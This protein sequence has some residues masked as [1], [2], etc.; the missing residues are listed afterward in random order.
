MDS[1][2]GSALSIASAVYI[3]TM[4]DEMPTTNVSV[5]MI[6]YH[7]TICSLLI[8][9]NCI[10]L[11]SVG[12]YSKERYGR[13]HTWFANKIV[14]SRAVALVIMRWIFGILHGI[15][16]FLF[17]TN[18]FVP[19]STDNY[20]N[21]CTSGINCTTCTTY[22]LME[23]TLMSLQAGIDYAIMLQVL[24]D[25]LVCGNQKSLSKT[26]DTMINVSIIL[27][28]TGATVLSLLSPNTQIY[29]S[30]GDSTAHIC[31]F[32]R[33]NN[34]SWRLTIAITAVW[35]IGVGLFILALFLF[36]LCKV[37]Q[38]IIHCLCQYFF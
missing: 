9:T 6:V 3:H 30:N 28:V 1:K 20:Q 17:F 19:F 8:V 36:E 7:H 32:T 23:T 24:K 33:T 21:N 29:T 34:Q 18:I 14:G 5:G 10:F 27:P 38:L 37:K 4:V 15:T 35:I 16:G 12:K 31:V 13:V 25:T 22:S 26:L 2:L 11:Y